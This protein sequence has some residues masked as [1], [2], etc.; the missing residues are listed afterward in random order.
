MESSLSIL[1]RPDLSWDDKVAYLSYTL[2]QMNGEDKTPPVRHLFIPGFYIREILM[3]ADM[4]LIGRKHIQGHPLELVYGALE[5]FAEAG[6]TLHKAPDG[7]VSKPGFQMVLH[8]LTPCLGR[9]VH[10]NPD[11]CRDINV[12][13]SRIAE[14]SAPV[15]ERGRQLA[16]ELLK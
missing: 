6:V 15:L 12:L 10:L 11:E 3:P 5:I 13:E 16:Q 2:S 1:R 4:F 14:P 7:F 8:T 9:T